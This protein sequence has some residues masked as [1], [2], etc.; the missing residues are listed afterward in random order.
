MKALWTLYTIL[1]YVVSA[2]IL[3]LV[4]GPQKWHVPHYI[5]L[6]GAPALI[7]GVRTLL[8]LLFDWQIG[9]R[10]AYVDDLQKQR[11]TK[12][13]E[14]K[15]ATKY[16]STQELLQK[17]G[18][19]PRQTPSKSQQGTKRKVVSPQDQPQR[20]GLPPPPTANIV[21]PGS[22]L[23]NT[24]QRPN[25]P[26]SPIPNGYLRSPQSSHSMTTSPTGIHPES[27]GFAPNAFSSGVPPPK[28]AYDKPSNWYDRIFDVILG[29]DETLAKN[30]LVLICSNCRLVNG[31]APPGVQT[32][33]QVGI[34]RCSSCGTKNGVESDTKT[35]VK[36]M[37][38]IVRDKHEDWQKTSR[39]TDSSP[40]E[41]SKRINSST[42][43]AAAMTEVQDSEDD[44][45]VARDSPAK[46]GPGVDSDGDS[47]GVTKRVTRSA[48][49]KY[50][51][52][53]QGW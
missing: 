42:E 36:Q 11:E 25:G 31:Q 3:V 41:L 12:I 23:P 44:G 19:A 4:L 53:D 14:L 15:K 8:G 18:A 48:K 24:P 1:A 33:E 32:L 34:W 43:G 2:A 28:S 9:R 20:T 13:N 7:Y 51:D 47:Q 38:E 35:M 30:R 16:D 26:V 5:G 22:S 52:E 29:E 21:R 45:E 39:G 17:Y 37:T 49:K 40:E 6:V 50:D 27:P 46:T 10:Q